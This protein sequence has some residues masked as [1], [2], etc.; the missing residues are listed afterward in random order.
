MNSVY[1]LF[2]FENLF[3][4]SFKF[5]PF[6]FEFTFLF[7][8][9]L[10]LS[11][12]CFLLFHLL[13]FLKHIALFC[14]NLTAFFP[15]FF[16]FSIQANPKDYRDQFG[17]SL[18]TKN[19]I[20]V[21]LRQ[22]NLENKISSTS[23]V[24]GSSWEGLKGDVE[25]LIRL[26]ESG[27]IDLVK[28]GLGDLIF[29]LNEYPREIK[30]NNKDLSI[31]AILN[32]LLSELFEIFDQDLNSKISIVEAENV[33]RKLNSSLGTNISIDAAREFIRRLDP[34]GDGFVDIEEFKSGFLSLLTSN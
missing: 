11:P 30:K 31:Q 8:L 19:Q 15:E 33:F 10:N 12:P 6:L 27:S 24:N 25:G 3:Q 29:W 18:L 21:I 16:T 17:S 28:E 14:S 34:N 4:L 7:I 9:L 20:E 22:H 13:H 1:F 32:A 26:Y 2:Q 5:F 23:R